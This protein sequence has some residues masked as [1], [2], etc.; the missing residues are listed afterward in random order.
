M[1]I[2]MLYPVILCGGVGTRLW[3]IS[4][5]SLPKQFLKM[6]EQRSLY[7]LTCSRI[8]NEMFQNPIIVSS[9]KYR[10]L[11]SQQMDEIGL[12]PEAILLEP[13]V[14]NTTAAVLLSC[15]YLMEKDKDA[16]LI[17]MPSDH[18]IADN[19]IFEKI[20]QKAHPLAEMGKIVTFGIVPN[21]PATGYGYIEIGLEGEVK[22]FHEKPEKQKAEKMLQAGNFFWN[23]GIFVGKAKTFL[24]EAEVYANETTKLTRDSLIEAMP[25]MGFLRP[26]QTIWE[27]LSGSSIDLDIIEKTD[28][29]ECIPFEC[30]WSDLGDW[31]ELAKYFSGMNKTANTEKNMTRGKVVE[32]NS[33][34]CILWN[35]SERSVLAVSGQNEK[36]IVATDDAILVSD[37]DDA[38]N[39]KSLVNKLKSSGADEA[40]RSVRSYR[41]WGW[42][43]SLVKQIGYQVKRICV[44]PGQR[45]SLQSHNYRS[46]HWVVT[47]GKAEVQIEDK[48]F[49]LNVNQS[50]YIE[51]KQKHRLSNFQSEPLVLIEVQN[52]SYLGEDDIERFDDDYLRI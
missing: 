48:K 13:K 35:S 32:L 5:E 39:V 42:Y 30:E 29:L 4:R 8:A 17:I 16:I 23:S 25:D 26:N 46:E 20:I 14:K 50:I 37:K 45:L 40:V 51:A 2:S 18:Q 7:Q 10:F 27:R 28:L 36:I 11:V 24:D 52:G 43:E 19:Y 9:E 47:S 49:I 21:S 41:P 34:N 22:S 6:F 38:D 33:T 12:K 3:P 31:E 44:N 15:H 1:R